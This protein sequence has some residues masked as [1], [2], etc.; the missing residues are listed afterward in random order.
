MTDI[1][2]DSKGKQDDYDVHGYSVKGNLND[3]PMFM[4]LVLRIIRL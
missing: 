2:C 4:V 1:H 3:S